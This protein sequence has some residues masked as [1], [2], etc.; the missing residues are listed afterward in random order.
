MTRWVGGIGAALVAVLAL[1]GG[2]A[3]QDYPTRTVKIIVPFPPGGTADAMP[4]IVAEFLTRKWG[5]AVIIENRAGAGGN[6]GGR[7]RLPFR[8][9]RLHA[10]RLAAAAARHQPESLSPSCR[11]IRPSSFRWR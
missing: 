2:V 10:V 9:G 7:G 6:I 4:R 8:S 11:S 1:S 5:Q 3:A